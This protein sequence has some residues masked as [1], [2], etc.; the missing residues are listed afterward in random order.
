MVGGAVRNALLGLAVGEIDVATT[1]VPEEVVRR[2]AA[3]GLQAGADRHRTRHHHRRHRQ[4]SVRSDDLAP[5]RRN[6]R[7]P[8]QGGVRPRLEG[9]RR[10]AR[11]HR[12]TR[13]PPRA[14]VRSTTMSAASP[15]LGAPRALHRRREATYRG[16]LSAHPALLPFP[17]RLRP[18]I[19]RTRGA[20][21]LH[22]RPRR[23]RPAF[24][25]TR[26]HGT[27]EASARAARDADAGRR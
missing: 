17:C 7:P 24:A 9:R 19:T 5:R 23:P 18:A 4:A 2:V 8:R 13:C 11:F 16:R 14:T 6:L 20:G 26:A 21:R 27:D 15:I 12:S 1:A 3:A 10:A 25:R 22:R